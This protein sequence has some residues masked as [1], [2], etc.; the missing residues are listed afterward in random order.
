M[1]LSS[2]HPPTGKP[3]LLEQVREEVRNGFRGGAGK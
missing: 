2:R 1:N 3:R